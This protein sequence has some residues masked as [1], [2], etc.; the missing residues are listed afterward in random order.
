MKRISFALLL[1]L[2]VFGSAA[3]ATNGEGLTG[4]VEAF[5]VV[6]LE[7]GKESFLPAGKASPKD[8]IEYRLTYKNNGTELVQSIFITDPIPSGT[9]YIEA[10]ASQP[11]NGRVEFSIDGGRTYRNWPI[12]IIEKTN[13]G[14]EVVKRAT[15]DMVTHIRWT[16]NDTFQPERQITVSYRT[17]ID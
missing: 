9:Q 5:R 2:T 4:T 11:D 1:A 8:V 16:L 3:L 12:E 14:R 10:S 13:D 17:V 7:D 6:K 15:P